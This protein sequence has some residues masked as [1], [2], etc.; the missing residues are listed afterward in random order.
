MKVPTIEEF[1][2]WID[3]HPELYEKFY[4][5]SQAREKKI[6]MQQM[7]SPISL[8]CV[9]WPDEWTKLSVHKNEPYTQDTNVYKFISDY[10]EG[11]EYLRR[12]FLE[13]QDIKYY[14]CLMEILPHCIYEHIVDNC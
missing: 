3:K 12:K 13:T 6:T 14:E 11:C 2:E 9:Q 8:G 4:E 1:N 7:S 10:L 5:E